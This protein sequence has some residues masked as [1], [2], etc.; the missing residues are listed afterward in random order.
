MTD[1]S[2][3]VNNYKTSNPMKLAYNSVVNNDFDASCKRKISPQIFEMI[4]S[5]IQPDDDIVRNGFAMIKH[6]TDDF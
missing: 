2:E 6:Q 3:M 4:P 1:L 5:V